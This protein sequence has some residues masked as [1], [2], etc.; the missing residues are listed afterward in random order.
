VLSAKSAT[1]VQ[2]P[3]MIRLDCARPRAPA[4]LL[5][6]TKCHDFLRQAQGR[7]PDIPEEVTALAP[8][9]PEGGLH[10]AGKPRIL[11]A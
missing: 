7:S 9:P 2:D 4:E 11:Q 8:A 10:E 5:I 1:A 3:L 6:S